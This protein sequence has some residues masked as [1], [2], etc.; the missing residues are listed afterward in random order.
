MNAPST[1]YMSSVAGAFVEPVVTLLDRLFATSH[2]GT[3]EVQ[4]GARENGYSISACLL[5]VVMLEAFIVRAKVITRT[6]FARQKCQALDFF[7]V[8]YPKCPLL[9][10]LE[11]LFV[12]RDVIAQ[13]HVWHIE[14]ETTRGR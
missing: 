14:F 1:Q 11:E 12:L 13:N 6:T 8:A 10:E 4:T 9:A 5:L 7:R 3:T 2:P